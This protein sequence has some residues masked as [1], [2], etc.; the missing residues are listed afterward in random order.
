M[1]AGVTRATVSYVLSGKA[2][3][4][5]ITPG[6]VDRVE[7]AARKL[8]YQPNLAARALAMGRTQQI[9]IVVPSPEYFRNYY[10]GPILA[11]IERSAAATNYSVLLLASE[12]DPVRCAEAY[13][14]QRRVDVAILFLERE[15]ESLARLP[16]APVLVGG[17]P[18]G[19]RIPVV[20]NDMRA[21]V[22]DIVS[23][24]CG[25]GRKR[26]AWL[27]L[28]QA[29]VAP[30]SDRLVALKDACRRRDV[31][32]MSINIEGASEDVLRRNDGAAIT[33]WREGIVRSGFQASSVDAVVCWN[34][35]AALGLYAWMTER[36]LR[37]GREIAVVGFDD[38]F[39]EICLPPLASVSFDEEEI[40]RVAV[41]AALRILEGPEATA[42]LL[43]ESPLLVPARF[44]PRESCGW[45]E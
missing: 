7:K 45:T 21:A 1:L 28:A 27:G 43:A 6:V 2:K 23:H 14:R 9:A 33:A 25:L 35:V 3:D 18:A 40:G 30:G 13:L 44:R 37:P 17:Q 41:G 20:L 22:E 19:G 26:V 36:G 39:A 34:D 24:L 4:L 8:D 11:G 10:W 32:L 31:E 29:A 16:V 38:H 42:E 5:K 12:P 15:T